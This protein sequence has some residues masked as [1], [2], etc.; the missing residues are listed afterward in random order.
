MASWIKAII[1]IVLPFIAAGIGNLATLPNI[2]SWYAALD[3]P[4][5]NPPNWIFGPVW[6]VLYI[7]MGVALFL[8]WSNR[9]SAPRKAYIFFGSQLI[10]NALWSQVFFGLHWTWGGVLVIVS[11]LIFIVLTMREFA[12]VSKVAAALLV[13]Y[14]GWVLFATALNVSLAV[15]N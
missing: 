6:T 2:P 10:L 7:L 12:R 15:I 9:K 5:F 13:P 3:K 8:V 4:W 11:L 1:S 14:V